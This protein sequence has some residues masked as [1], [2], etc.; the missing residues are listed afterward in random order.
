MKQS[1]RIVVTLNDEMEIGYE[2]GIQT[3]Y[4]NSHLYSELV[5]RPS[6]LL[7]A[8]ET[9]WVT[10]KNSLTDPSVSLEP[11]LLAERQTTV[12]N[13][14]KQ[15]LEN[16]WSVIEQTEEEAYEYYLKIPD[17]VLQNVGTWYFSFEVREIANSANPTAYSVIST[18]D[19]GSFVVNNSLSGVPG[20]VPTDLDIVSLYNVAKGSVDS[21]EQSATAAAQSATQAQTYAAQAK[22]SAEDAQSVV[23]GA[24]DE[25]TKTATEQATVAATEATKQAIV[26][27]TARAT[28]RENELQTAITNEANTR[29][30]Q[31][32]SLNT[33]IEGLRE[34]IQNESHFRGYLATNAEIQALSGTPNDFAYS[35]ESGTV[36]I[37]QTATGWTDSG[38][39]VPD[40]SVPASN[41][42]PLMD[43]TGSAGTA[44][45]YSKGD[46]RHP[47]DVTKA[48]VTRVEA[49]EANYVTT[50]T[51][52][53]VTAA[54]TFTQPLKVD[55]GTPVS[56]HNI[57]FGVD[58][59]VRRSGTN[60]VYEYPARSGVLAT[61]A[62][63]ND[64][65]ASAITTALNT[66]V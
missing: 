34:D 56:P 33:D 49:I 55:D 61:L 52:Q 20:G 6:F 11:T 62:D 15:V 2:S 7:G 63:I 38:K 37:Y 44:T 32:A 17:A 58:N 9:L 16:G 27:E 51:E 53:T 59:I 31:V 13:S 18:S 21:A 10:I 23:V 54:K 14:T 19:Y 5:V 66:P 29:S 1:N 40:Q 8:T 46:H 39:P 26:D 41:A 36:W 45:E 12:A 3:L 28:A 60:R 64:A 4:L 48:D 35:A 57:A 65:I 22:Q 42:I 50:N 43:G 47:S 24:I 25:I 30:A